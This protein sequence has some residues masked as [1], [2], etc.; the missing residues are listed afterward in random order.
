YANTVRD[1]NPLMDSTAVA[2]FKHDEIMQL[3]SEIRIHLWALLQPLF[4]K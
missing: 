1:L 3:L 4:S 2:V